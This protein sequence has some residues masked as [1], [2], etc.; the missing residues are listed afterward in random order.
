MST[1]NGKKTEAA[2]LRQKKADRVREWLKENEYVYIIK[3]YREF[4]I[5]VSDCG[6]S[7]DRKAQDLDIYNDVEL[8]RWW[9]AAC[10]L[11]RTE[12]TDIDAALEQT[13]PASRTE[14]SA[15]A[16]KEVGNE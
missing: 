3:T 13:W 14:E 12:A 5:I 15:A 6:D 4:T 8:A 2:S 9:D 7:G 1:T 10:L 16:G 11:L